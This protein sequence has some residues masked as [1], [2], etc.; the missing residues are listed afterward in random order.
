MKVV[1][2][3]FPDIDCARQIGTVLVESQLIACINLVPAVESIYSWEGKLVTDQEV[4]GILKTNDKQL[5]ELEAKLTELH[6]FEV[7]EF[8]I[9]DPEGGSQ[10]YLDWVL[11]VS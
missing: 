1:L 3:T 7:P 10:A 4:L 9:I 11:G 8:I 2:A 5:L 6:P